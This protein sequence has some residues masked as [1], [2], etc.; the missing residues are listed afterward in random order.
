MRI[1]IVLM[2]L[3]CIVIGII[4]GMVAFMA[5]EPET[6]VFPT[7]RP[8]VVSAV[9][10]EKPIK[11][12]VE[13]SSFLDPERHE[14]MLSGPDRFST[15]LNPQSDSGEA[16]IFS[17]YRI[18]APETPAASRNL[19][20][21]PNGGESEISVEVGAASYFLSLSQQLTEGAPAE[22]PAGMSQFVA[23]PITT[24]NATKR[25]VEIISAD[26]PQRFDFAKP[27]FVCLPAQ[28]WHHDEHFGVTDPNLCWLVYATSDLGGQE[29]TVSTL[30]QFGLSKLTVQPAKWLCLPATKLGPS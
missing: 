21:S 16:L 8:L 30:D 10:P 22:N 25:N 13:W 9:S 18:P 23:Y 28:E 1:V 12:G 7:A 17:W 20:V 24:S 26:G 3:A 11:H 19:R 4:A 15:E 2:V 29:K 27:D 6:K 5:G 14:S